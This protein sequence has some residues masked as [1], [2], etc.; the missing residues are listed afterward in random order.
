MKLTLLISAIL[1]IWQ[2]LSQYTVVNS[3]IG[4]TEIKL[5]L[6]YTGTSDYYVKPKSL[7][8]KQLV[9]LFK[10]HTFNDFSFKIYDPNNKRF[11]VPQGGVFPKDQQSEFSYPIQMAAYKINFTTNHFSFLIVRKDTD[12][13]LFDSSVV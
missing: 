3:S 2:A 9:F 8:I 1:F 10:A 7:I 11:E 4:S 6:N 5:F 13:V 12:A